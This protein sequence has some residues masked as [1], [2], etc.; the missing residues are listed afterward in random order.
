MLGVVVGEGGAATD[1]GVFIVC[2]NVPTH[3]M[4]VFIETLWSVVTG[5][6][7]VGIGS[8]GGTV[9]GARSVTHL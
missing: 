3:V 9:F 1:A 6:L 8:V 4:T 5:Y 7:T 2:T